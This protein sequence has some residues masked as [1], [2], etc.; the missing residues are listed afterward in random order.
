MTSAL[1]GVQA[2]GNPLENEEYRAG[3]QPWIIEIAAEPLSGMVSWTV[4][5]TLAGPTTGTD[6]TTNVY[7]T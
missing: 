6:G 1:L 7:I 4:N 5:G 3:W 2:G